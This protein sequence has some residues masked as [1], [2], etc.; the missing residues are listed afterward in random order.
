MESTLDNNLSRHDAEMAQVS[1]ERAQR[2]DDPT[3]YVEEQRNAIETVKIENTTNAAKTW[4]DF[5]TWADEFTAKRKEAV[6]AANSTS[7]KQPEA[8]R[9]KIDKKEVNVWKLPDRS[10][11]GRVSP[12]G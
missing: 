1:T 5:G 4:S 9:P 3:V 11:E 7:F 6:T 8:L 12:L 2:M 10:R